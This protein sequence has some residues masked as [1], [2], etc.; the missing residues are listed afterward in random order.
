[1]NSMS[2]YLHDEGGYTVF[3][4]NYPTTRGTV[5][6][7]AR[8]LDRIIENLD[9]IDEINFVGHSLGNLVVRHYLGDHTRPELGIEPDPRIGRIVMLGPP[10]QGAEIA[11]ALAGVGLFHVVAG[12]SGTQLAAQWRQLESHL[13]VP[14]CEFGI[15]AGGRGAER[16]F[17][18]WLTGDNDLVVGVETTRL[19]G[20][21]DFAV[22]PVLHSF[23]MNDPAAQEY[24][25]RFLQHGYFVS[26]EARRPIAP[27]PDGRLA[28]QPDRLKPS[29]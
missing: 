5:A 21:S 18:P 4:V 13:A 28:R 25:L 14:Q 12:A 2:R 3:N 8:S 17:N 15:L 23:M 6:D 10:N 22:L 24:T 19:A 29:P 9:G 7:H 27:E 16:G 1:M 26:A 11:E 20:A